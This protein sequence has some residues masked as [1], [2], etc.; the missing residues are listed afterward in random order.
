MVFRRLSRNTDIV[1]LAVATL[2]QF[3]YALLIY[4]RWGQTFVAA[5]DVTHTYIARELWFNM[6]NMGGNWLPLYHILVAPFTL[7]PVLYESGLAGVIVNAIA[8]GLSSLLLHRIMPN[9]YGVL[10]SLLYSGNY[11]LLQN[12]GSALGW[13]AQ[14]I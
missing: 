11:I 9:R 2:M 8:T 13:R 5:D 6:S 7:V 10:A 1:I 3:V 12:G 14:P 4:Q